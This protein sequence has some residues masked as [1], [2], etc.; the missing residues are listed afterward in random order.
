VWLAKQIADHLGIFDGVLASNGLV[1]PEL[2][3]QLQA[4]ASVVRNALHFTVDG[5]SHQHHDPADT[6]ILSLLESKYQSSETI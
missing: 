1:N 5:R 2:L 4:A 3:L 6:K